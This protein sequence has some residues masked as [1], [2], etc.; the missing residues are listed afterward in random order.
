MDSSDGVG[1]RCG[2]IGLRGQTRD[3]QS[4]GKFDQS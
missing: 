1:S 3:G 2:G 4:L